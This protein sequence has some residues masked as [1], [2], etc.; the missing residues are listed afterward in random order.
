MIIKNYQIKLSEIKKYN[1][2]IF[3]FHIVRLLLNQRLSAIVRDTTLSG[4]LTFKAQPPARSDNN[5]SIKSVFIAMQ[6]LI[7]LKLLI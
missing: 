7:V 3:C 6:Q 4:I 1:K 2:K 5:K